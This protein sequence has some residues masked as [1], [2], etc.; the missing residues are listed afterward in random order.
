MVLQLA[1]LLEEL[2]K[3]NTLNKTYFS[4]KSRFSQIFIKVQLSS[5]KF[6]VESRFRY[7]K[8]PKI[9][10]LMKVGNPKNY[11]LLKKIRAKFHQR[12]SFPLPSS[13]I[14]F[15]I[16]KQIQFHLDSSL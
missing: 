7:Y 9:I 10:I 8:V 1:V 14:F 6:I 4:Q 2:F 3:G 12:F 16:N 13:L 11:F 15:S 5:T